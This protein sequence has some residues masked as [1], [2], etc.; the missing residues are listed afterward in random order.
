LKPDSNEAFAFGT[1]PKRR[2][3]AEHFPFV[4][5]LQ[6]QAQPGT[7]HPKRRN[8]TIQSIGNFTIAAGIH[9]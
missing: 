2:N 7:K 5:F 3:K 1:M 4:S 6:T 8:E 9:G